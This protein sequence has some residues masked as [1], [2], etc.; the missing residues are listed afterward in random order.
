MASVAGP[1]TITYR[2]DA[3][4]YSGRSNLGAAVF[5]Q[6]LV[7]NRLVGD[8]SYILRS[9]QGHRNISTG[10]KCGLADAPPRPW[11]LPARWLERDALGRGPLCMAFVDGSLVGR[12]HLP[13]SESLPKHPRL[14]SAH[15]H[16]RRFG[17]VP[18]P[19]IDQPGRRTA[20]CGASIR[21]AERTG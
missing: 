4:G 14:P 9:L 15:R 20:A 8:P 11:S 5:E 13:V 19:I 6:C 1:A 21:N 2:N 18:H 12:L 16:R 3:G 17:A 10:G 7:R